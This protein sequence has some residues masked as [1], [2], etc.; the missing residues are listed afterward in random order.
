MLN[1]KLHQGAKVV[2]W[3]KI[4]TNAKMQSISS[5]PKEIAMSTEFRNQTTNAKNN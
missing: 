4:S 3:A 2:P 1:K 5:K